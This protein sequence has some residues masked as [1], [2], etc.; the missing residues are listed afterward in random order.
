MVEI[1]CYTGGTCGDLIT[2]LIDPKDAIVKKQS[3]SLTPNRCKLKK[4]FLFANDSDKKQYIDTIEY[5]SI[6]SH[7]TNFHITN[8]HPIIGITI[9]NVNLAMWAANR[10]KKIHQPH[11]WEEMSS[12]CGAKSVEEYA[13]VLLDYS[14]MIVNHSN[15]IIKLEQILNGDATNCLQNF[16]LPITT[17]AKNLYNSWLLSQESLQ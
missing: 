13:Q 9:E 15:R 1:V 16:N 11:V 14:S 10:F 2:A 6:P 12:A 17:E 4:P 3:V 5:N 8:K 7:D